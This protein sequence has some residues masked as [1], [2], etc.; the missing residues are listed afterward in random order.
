MFARHEAEDEQFFRGG[1]VD[2]VDPSQHSQPMAQ[3][4]SLL[5]QQQHPARAAGRLKSPSRLNKT[6]S[7]GKSKSPPP[8][9]PTRKQANR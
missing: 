4:N 5:A 8:K 3:S 6:P 2:M 1:D 7:K 9:M